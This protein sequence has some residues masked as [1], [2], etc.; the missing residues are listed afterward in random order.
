MAATSEASTVVM[1]SVFVAVSSSAAGR[2]K[3][4]PLR[5]PDVVLSVLDQMA[6]VVASALAWIVVVTR[7]PVNTAHDSI[8]RPLRYTSLPWWSWCW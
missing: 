7:N 6:L 8:S 5:H 2:T 3:R 4:R 1:F